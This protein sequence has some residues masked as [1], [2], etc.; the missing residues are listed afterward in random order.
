MNFAW[1]FP[2][3]IMGTMLVATTGNWFFLVGSALGSLAASILNSQF[4][5][6]LRATG[7]L[8]FEQQNFFVGDRKLT[9]L[10]LFWP[11]ELKERVAAFI[12]GMKSEPQRELIRQKLVESN[13]LLSEKGLGYIGF[14]GEAPVGINLLDGFPHLA[15]F[16]PTGSGKSFLFE[17]FFLS[18]HAQPYPFQFVLIDFK[19]AATFSRFSNLPR[20]SG[21]FSEVD[22]ELLQ[23]EFERLELLMHQRG[24][25]PD[26]EHNPVFI[27]VD[28]FAHLAAKFPK[29]AMYF[30]NFLSRG[31]SMGIHVVL[32]TQNL[33]SIP[34]GMQSH[35]RT[36]LVVGSLEKMELLGLGDQQAF[37]VAIGTGSRPGRL[38]SLGQPT[39]QFWF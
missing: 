37:P 16:G 4:Q 19:M 15:I 27:L 9:R 7:E 10:A 28:E 32:A 13:F 29:S 25:E 23:A 33:A 21:V 5:S 36:R 34:R 39:E 17:R 3:L 22:L 24:Q 31:R 11:P 2:S 14:V 6:Y 26:F 18:L 35:L 30:E 1:L 8:R 12:A 38:V 20:V